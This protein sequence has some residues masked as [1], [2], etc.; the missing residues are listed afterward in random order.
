MRCHKCGFHSFDYLSECKKCGSDLSSIRDS[1]GL[2]SVQPDIPFFLNVLLRGPGAGEAA[3]PTPEDLAAT[4]AEI[5][6]GP[7][8]DLDEPREDFAG[9]LPQAPPGPAPAQAQPEEIELVLED[10]KVADEEPVI[11][12]SDADLDQLSDRKQMEGLDL[13]LD[14]DLD[15][16]P[17]PTKLFP[18]APGEAAGEEPGVGILSLD[19]LKLELDSDVL[20]E[21]PLPGAPAPAPSPTVAPES[22]EASG[23]PGLSL[24]LEDTPTL[25][26]SPEEMDRIVKSVQQPSEEVPE[27]DLSLDLDFDA[28]EKAPAEPPVGTIPEPMPELDLNLEEEPTLR[29]E[30]LE[31]SSPPPASAPPAPEPPLEVP[32]I[33]LDLDETFVE[34]KPP[35]SGFE[36][37]IDE[38][39]LRK[40]MEL[41]STADGILGLEPIVADRPREA[42]TEPPTEPLEISDSDLVLELTDDDLEGLIEELE[43]TSPKGEKKPPVKPS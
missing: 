32:E 40:T 31:S 21:V 2:L 24:D 33:T 28:Q 6:L 42:S 11:E 30:P 25:Q 4:I 1:L 17:S 13:K 20:E 43:E 19:D 8:L 12:L 16:E 35:T 5:D 34:G 15:A 14:L 23:I 9:T 18:A 29:L 27:L 41:E 26:I 39:E 3:C 38:E 10:L 7:E 37:L 22:K 36:L